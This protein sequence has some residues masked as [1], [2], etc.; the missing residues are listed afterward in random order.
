MESLFDIRRLD[1]LMEYIKK[2]RRDLSSK[3]LNEVLYDINSF[4]KR[5]NNDGYKATKTILLLKPEKAV[6]AEKAYEEL[7]SLLEDLKQDLTLKKEKSKIIQKLEVII[8]KMARLRILLNISLEL[9]NP[10]IKK[11][12][13]MSNLELSK[14]LKNLPKTKRIKRSNYIQSKITAFTNKGD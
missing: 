11:I 4:I 5:A 7:S 12:I 6:T 13:S 8:S 2:L 9:P 1:E 3:P 14:K 10:I